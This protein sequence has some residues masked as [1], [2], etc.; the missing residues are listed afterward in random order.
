MALFILV[1]VDDLL[2]AAR[3]IND[4]VSECG[5]GNAKSKSIP[6][7][8]GAALSQGSYMPTPE[9]Y[10]CLFG[11][12]LYLSI[13][14]RPDISL[15]VGALSRHM[16]NAMAACTC[17]LCVTCMALLSMACATPALRRCLA[18]EQM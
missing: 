14:T 12:M 3:A 10:S 2:M 5:L 7:P 8:V 15:A 13:T 17:A 18:C 11:S 16:A 1:Y 6:L 4:I 9:P